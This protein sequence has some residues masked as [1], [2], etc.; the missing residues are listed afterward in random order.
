[1]EWDLWNWSHDQ[2]T[3]E[4]N[5]SRQ[6]EWQCD[7][8]FGYGTDVIEERALDE[9]SCIQV[10]RILIRKADA[11]LD[12][13][14]NDLVSLQ[15]ELA[16]AEHE[17][18][19]ER[20]CN[21]LN[22]KIGCLDIAIKSLKS[23]SENDIEV[24]LSLHR[25]PAEKIQDLMRKYLPEND[26][27][28]QQ[29]IVSDVK[30]DGS[31]SDILVKEEFGEVATPAEKCKETNP[32][33]NF[34]ENKTNS[35][36]KLELA[37]GDSTFH[38][39]ECLRLAAGSCVEENQLVI[40]DSDGTTR[41]SDAT[42]QELNCE[43]KNI[44]LKHEEK[45]SC[46]IEI[47]KVDENMEAKEQLATATKDL[48]CEGNQAYK[49]T[50][51]SNAIVEY[52]S[53]DAIIRSAAVS[54][55]CIPAEFVPTPPRTS[56]SDDCDTGEK[57]A[58]L[59][60]KLAR[61][62][63]ITIP[64]EFVLSPPRTLKSDDCDME[65]KVAELSPKLAR[66]ERINI[67]PSK[68]VSSDLLSR[69]VVNGRDSVL[70]VTNTEKLAVALNNSTVKNPIMTKLNNVG[71]TEIEKSQKAIVVFD[72]SVSDLSG[73]HQSQSAMRK[74]QSNSQIIRETMSAFPSATE[75]SSLKA[76]PLKRRKCEPDGDN[77]RL[78]QLMGGS[79]SVS[80]KPAS[81]SG[82]VDNDPNAMALS[83]LAEL[84]SGRRVLDGMKI[85][86]LKTI[87]K[88]LDLTKLSKLKKSELVERI[89]A[90]RK[91]RQF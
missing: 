6:S 33:T 4:H 75:S 10:L 35:P 19:P 68:Y 83:L 14:E 1:M 50:N 39:P 22:D 11:E 64:A 8:Y 23:K 81:D 46:N 73:K 16:F 31:T 36:N 7:F 76:F 5:A 30:P 60:T 55:R 28:P 66:N 15:T 54:M 58:E 40:S 67:P 82:S 88:F 17:E 62:E 56:K 91:E 48:L 49:Q 84:S 9:K 71:E 53:L 38:G 78:V 63:R 90:K 13:L 12:E 57:V 61:N 59:S 72:N 37:N 42:E 44:T 41:C 26:K 51:L 65:E 43:N 32:S 20:C 45:T 80:N 25:E 34:H 27:Q 3:V 86:E 69:I 24:Q 47:P 89:S 29:V 74:L 18:W 70:P 21:A 85:Q 2:V 52:T 79:G 87:A 77:V